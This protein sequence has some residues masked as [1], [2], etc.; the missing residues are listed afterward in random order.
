[1]GL[2]AATRGVS[3]LLAAFGVVGG[4]YLFAD[5]VKQGFNL[6][7]TLDSLNFAQKTIISNNAELA[8]T[9]SFLAQITEDYG[10]AVVTTTERYTK[11]LAAAKQSNVSLN[12]TEEI[13]GTMT[14]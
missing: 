11:F 5:L 13:F 14:K 6:A 9:Q 7:R 2:L 1:G 12:D 8:R 3:S 4:L 10:A